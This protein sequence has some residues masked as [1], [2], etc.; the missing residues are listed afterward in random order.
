MGTIYKRLTSTKQ[1]DDTR[2][3]GWFFQSEVY[4]DSYHTVT[5]YDEGGFEKY[6]AEGHQHPSEETTDTIRRL[7]DRII[8]EYY[9]MRDNG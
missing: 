5:L 4:S 2:T 7:T 9:E 6:R 3:N 1:W 8:D